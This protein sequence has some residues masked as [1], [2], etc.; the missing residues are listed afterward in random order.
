MQQENKCQYCGYTT[1]QSPLVVCDAVTAYPLPYKISYGHYGRTFKNTEP[2][3]IITTDIMKKTPQFN[4][5]RFKTDKQMDNWLASV[6]HAA[7]YLVSFGQ[8]M[9]K[10]WVH[11][12][13]EILHT[14]FNQDIYIGKFINIEK[15]A[16]DRA[17]EIWNDDTECYETY[18]K[19]IP[20]EIIY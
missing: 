13:G 12:T 18:S 17:L 9:Q 10:I 7:I 15:L 4:E 16:H 3:K 19:L 6:T 14:D 8:D 1:H 2:L 11:K 5:L 20:E